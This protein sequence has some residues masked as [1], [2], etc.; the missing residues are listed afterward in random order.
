MAAPEVSVGLKVITVL[1]YL[2]AWVALHMVETVAPVETAAQ[3]G[4]L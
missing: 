3:A 1:E 4:Q 2:V